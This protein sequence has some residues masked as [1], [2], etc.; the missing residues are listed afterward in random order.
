M[1]GKKGISKRVSQKQLPGQEDPVNQKVLKAQREYVE[2]RDERMERTR[3]EVEKKDILL[4]T[5][6]AEKVKRHR[7]PETGEVAIIETST[8]ENVKVKKFEESEE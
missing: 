2:A 6:K 1:A 5:M 8:K 7:D 4:A 3:I